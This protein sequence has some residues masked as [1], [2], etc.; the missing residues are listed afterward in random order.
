VIG[1]INGRSQ[2]EVSGFF[3][4]IFS[5]LDNLRAA[6]PSLGAAKKMPS[7]I[8]TATL[9]PGTHLHLLGLDNPN[10]SLEITFIDPRSGQA[11]F[12]HEGEFEG[13]FEGEREGQF[14]GA[15]LHPTILDENEP[16][17]GSLRLEGKL[18]EGA[19]LEYRLTT[20][21]QLSY[22]RVGELEVMLPN[23]AWR[24]VWSEE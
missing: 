5:G 22:D 1:R 3:F 6:S 18:V 20:G 2:P 15:V 8:D 21:E 9:K 14:L 19:E 10:K 7:F 23:A 17:P 16:P 24:S 11:L 4:P 13:E 12:I